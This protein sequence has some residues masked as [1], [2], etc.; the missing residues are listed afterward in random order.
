MKK[1]QQ[2]S[3][4]VNIL[5]L[6]ILLA[7][8]VYFGVS[9]YIAYV[10]SKPTLSP[11]TSPATVV[12]ADFENVEFTTSDNFHLKGWLFHAASNK[13]VVFVS[14]TNQNRLNPDYGTVFI[15]RELLA[16]GYN[17]LLFDM[18]ATGESDGKLITFGQNEKYDIPAAIQFLESKGFQDKYIGIIAN[19]LGAISTLLAINR[20]QKVGGIVLDSAAAEVKPIVA[21]LLKDERHIP[22]FLNPGIFYTGRIFLGIKLDTLKPVDMLSTVPHKKLL[23]LHGDRDVIIPLENSK[24]LLSH[25][26]RDSKLVIFKKAGH[27]QTYKTSPDLYRKE[28][29]GYLDEEL[30]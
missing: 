2:K 15:A 30:K 28:V 13:V 20:L 9:Y 10:M 18:R 26:S 29:F 24:T 22:V 3:L 5:L 12:S 1:K 7:A 23:F 11:V 27:I 16:K 6:L 14:G 21:H 17:V 19:S 8:I 25:A 4:I